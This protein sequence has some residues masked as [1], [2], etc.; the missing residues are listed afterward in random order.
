MRRDRYLLLKNV[1]EFA[2]FLQDYV[3]VFSDCGLKLK[4]N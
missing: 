2:D 3:E 1:K 4:V